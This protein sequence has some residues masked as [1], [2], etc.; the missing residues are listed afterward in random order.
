MKLALLAG[1]DGVL[2]EEQ[3]ARTGGRG[4]SLEAYRDLVERATGSKA[5]GERA[6]SARLAAQLRAG[7]TP[8]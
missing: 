1:L 2:A 5:A 3:L 7:V 8:Q 4:L 6:A